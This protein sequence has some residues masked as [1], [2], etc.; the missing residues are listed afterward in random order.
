LPPTVIADGGYAYAYQDTAGSTACLTT[1]ALCSAGNT[2]APSSM[3][4]WGGGIG[5]SLNQ[6]MA[7][8]AQSPPVDPYAV[9]T[10]DTGIA[11][12]L[13]NLPSQGARL[14]INDGATPVD[15]CAVLTAASG[16]IPWSSFNTACWNGSGTA[17]SGAP[18][19]AT[20]VQFEV[21]ANSSP[22]AFDFCVTA[23]SF[24]Q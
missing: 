15:Y 4:V 9:P 13:S 1:A 2:E 16:T 11:Y 10:A 24:A 8:G 18:Q 21:T 14:I 20:H 3:T 19:T 12:A 22:A 6:A 7:T 5:F 17:L 23:V